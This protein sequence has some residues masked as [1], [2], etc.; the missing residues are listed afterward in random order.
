MSVTRRTFLRSPLG[1]AGGT[2]LASAGQAR[3]LVG[4]AEAEMAGQGI[5][6]PAAFACSIA[7]EPR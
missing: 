2:I 1:A 3:A 7:P 4:R 5:E 6:H